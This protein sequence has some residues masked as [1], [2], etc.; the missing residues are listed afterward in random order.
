MN[1]PLPNQDNASAFA[2]LAIELHSAGGVDET[3][4]VV[5]DFALQALGCDYAGVTLTRP[6]S[7]ADV[8]AVT[9]PVVDH[10]LRWQLETCD[11]PMQHAL[12]TST[13]VYVTD[14]AT[15]D[16]WP[17]WSQLVAGLAIGSVMHV[18]LVAKGVVIGV[19]SL[20]HDKPNAF[21]DDDE[22]IAYILA[23]HATVAI[24]TARHEAQ[25]A[26]AMDARKLV[27][28]AQGILM[29]RHDLTSDEAFNVLRRYS[30]DT[31]TKLHD[32]AEQVIASLR[33]G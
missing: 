29:E 11:G 4:Q 1:E 31:N 17:L 27:G 33:K 30:Q 14:A 7:R 20:Y 3:V 26:Q 12:A 24:A 10:V 15:D 21:S 18:P 22:A 9:D 16:R 5:V 2:R 8:V 13:A 6:R 25:L 23:R 19:L 32:L 28:Q